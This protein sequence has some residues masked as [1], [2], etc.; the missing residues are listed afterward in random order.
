MSCASSAPLLLSNVTTIT[1]NAGVSFDSAESTETVLVLVAPGA[2][3][4]KSPWL[5]ELDQG[6]YFAE[7]A[8]TFCPPFTRSKLFA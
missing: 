8:T 1:P 6:L 5:I 2:T 3:V 4:T 7:P